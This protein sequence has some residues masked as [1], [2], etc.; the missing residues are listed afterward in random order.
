M[1]T[2]K[3]FI[4]LLVIHDTYWNNITSNIGKTTFPLSHYSDISET[5]DS[6]VYS[7]YSS[8]RRYV[9]SRDITYN[10]I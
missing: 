9:H 2:T 1:Y 5:I 3:G 10:I 8:D 7:F 6:S 4:L